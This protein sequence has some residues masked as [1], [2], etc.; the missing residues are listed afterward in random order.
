MTNYKPLSLCI[1]FFI[2]GVVVFSGCSYGNGSQ[3]AAA[4]END[5][6]PP[7]VSELDKEKLQDD[8]EKLNEDFRAL[9]EDFSEISRSF[10][11]ALIVSITDWVNEHYDR[12]SEIQRKKLREFMD[13][14]KEKTANMKKMS[15]AALIDLLNDFKEFTEDLEKGEP[16]PADKKF[17]EE[18]VHI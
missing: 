11:N 14:L 3:L 12:L 4:A 18:Q 6:R 2:I 8:A 17:P 15:L 13:N 9:F 16:A 5:S 1:V 7:A 10:I